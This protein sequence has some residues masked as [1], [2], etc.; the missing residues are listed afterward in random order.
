MQR[1]FISFAKEDAKFRD[2]LVGQ[3]RN[4][5]SPF[6]FMDM[7]VK[8]AW[9]TQ[10]KTNCRTKIKGCDGFIVLLT[11]NT[12]TADGVLWEIKCALEENVPILGIYVHK[13]QRYLMPSSLRGQKIIFWHWNEIK[14]FI[15]QL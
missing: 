3:A 14:N 4:D 6:D 10:W 11:S 7:S 13:D 12:T 1:I 9:D 2:F 8:E 15:T 5:K